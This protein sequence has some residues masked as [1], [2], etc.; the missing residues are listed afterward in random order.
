MCLAAP[1]AFG[2]DEVK[3]VTDVKSDSYYFEAIVKS[4][5]L[6]YVY[7]NGSGEF[8]PDKT[9]SDLECFQML[10]NVFHDDEIEQDNF[11]EKDAAIE[12]PWYYDSLTWAVE[13]GIAEDE[14]ELNCKVIRM[15]MSQRCSRFLKKSIRSTKRMI[16]CLVIRI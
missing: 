16:V 10:Y 4:E 2:Q 11:E 9:V 13:R 1:A 7:G 14:T 12:K 3:I 6:G 8:M 15:G 5:M